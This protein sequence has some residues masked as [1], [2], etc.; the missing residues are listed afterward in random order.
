[1]AEVK[2]VGFDHL[3]AITRSQVENEVSSQAVILERMVHNEL[4]LIVHLK[5]YSQ[6]GTKHKYA[7]DIRANFP[8][9]TIVS[10]KTQEWDAVRAAKQSLQALAEQIRHRFH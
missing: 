5:V 6:T 3:D 1:V 8:G 2:Y 9:G 4:E 7:I 10:D